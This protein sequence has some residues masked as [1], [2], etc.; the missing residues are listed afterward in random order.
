MRL[1][2]VLSI[3]LMLV[4]RLP[5]APMC[6]SGGT[7]ASYEALGATGCTI[8]PQTV[9]DFTFSVV[10]SGGG[11]IPVT[12]ANITVTPMFGAGFYGTSFASTGFSVTG[13][14]FVN[15]LVGYT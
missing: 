5:A 15:Y 14:G 8:G 2:W 6:I 4:L 10:S 11:A 7:L 12:D 13:A 3:F 9:K 1:A